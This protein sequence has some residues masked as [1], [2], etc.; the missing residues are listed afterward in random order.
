MWPAAEAQVMAAERQYSRWPGA[1]V[2]SRASTLR[3]RRGD[4]SAPRLSGLISPAKP[5]LLPPPERWTQDIFQGGGAR[6]RLPGL[7]KARY[8]ELLSGLPQVGDFGLRLNVEDALVATQQTA[9]ASI[10]ASRM[11]S[12]KSHGRAYE[13]TEIQL[14]AGHRQRADGV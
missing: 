3:G 14:H 10:G 11:R 8:A 5:R 12:P 9:R 4:S 2:S 13:I 7:N 1:A 6:R